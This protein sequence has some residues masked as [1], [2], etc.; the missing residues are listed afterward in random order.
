MKASTTGRVRAR[1][2]RRAATATYLRSRSMNNAP[3]SRSRARLS[4]YASCKTGAAMKVQVR[5]TQAQALK[6]LTARSIRTKMTTIAAA[7]R[8][9]LRVGATTEKSKPEMAM[10]ARTIMG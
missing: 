10:N 4:A 6:R 5:T 9:R 1:I 7:P 2:R 8:T 3:A